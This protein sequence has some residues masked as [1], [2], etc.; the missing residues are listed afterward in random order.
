MTIQP[1]SDQVEAFPVVRGSLT[2]TQL[3]LAILALT[4]TLD[5]TRELPRGDCFADSTH[6]GFSTTRIPH[7]LTPK[8]NS[9][10]GAVGIRP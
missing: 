7:F 3:H 2:Y 9:K 6:L 1:V 4:L 10:L 5:W 8:K